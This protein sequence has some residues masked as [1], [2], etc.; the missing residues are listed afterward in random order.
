MVGEE[1]FTMVIPLHIVGE[2]RVEDRHLDGKHHYH[3][4]K[5]CYI[6][7]SEGS[8]LVALIVDSK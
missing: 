1:S 4:P 2:V 6:D 7:V 3:I 5:P 8:K